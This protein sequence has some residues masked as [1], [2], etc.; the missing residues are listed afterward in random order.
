MT[1]IQTSTPNSVSS[2]LQIVRTDEQ[3][4]QLALSIAQAA[5]DRKGAN[6]TL[7]R[8]ADVSYLADYF[9][10][11]TGFSSVQVRAIARSIEEKVETEWQQQPLRIEGQLEGNWVLIDYGDVIAHIFMPNEREFYS[12]EAFWGHAEQINYSLSHSS[13][14]R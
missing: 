11:V 8:V 10:I 6:I 13:E 1:N 2:A 3:S 9:V 12:L 4:R 14:I 7:L 5:D